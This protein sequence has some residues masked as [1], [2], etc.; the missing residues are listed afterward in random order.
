M[1][2]NTD[3][4]PATRLESVQVLRGFAAMLVVLIHAVQRQDRIGNPAEWLS[5]FSYVGAIGVDLFFIISGFV[6]ALSMQRYEGGSGAL[7]FLRQRAYRIVPSFWI[8]S[9]VFGALI[10][11]QGWTIVPMQVLNT[12][13]F[14]PIFDFGDYEAPV[15]GVGWTLAFEAVFY[16]V[17]SVV[18]MLR[19]PAWSLIPII[20]ALVLVPTLDT[21]NWVGVRFF[22]NSILLEFA[23][24]VLAYLLWSKGWLRRSLVFAGAI[25]GLAVIA[26]LLPGKDGN[27]YLTPPIYNNSLSAVRALVWGVP[28]FFIFLAVLEMKIGG[29]P[30]TR[31]MKLVGDASYSIYLTHQIVFF[32][33]GWTALQGDLEAVLMIV[34]AAAFG[35]LA[36]RLVEAP[37]LYRARS[38]RAQRHLGAQT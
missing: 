5:T 21:A 25:G 30:V 10:V 38:L 37:L 2:A 32:A 26:M 35:I 31:L 4:K 15:L 22:F 7:T 23:L 16:V 27:L 11:W 9:A 18:I 36:Y 17:V 6:M 3:P 33:I 29:G 34:A 24:G 19:L 28:C 12:L 8:W 13:T 20:A 1:V 14:I